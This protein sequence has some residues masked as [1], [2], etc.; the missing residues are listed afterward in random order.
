ME[1]LEVKFVLSDAEGFN[2]SVYMRGPR[3][4]LYIEEYRN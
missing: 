3:L 4:L 1:V 2:L